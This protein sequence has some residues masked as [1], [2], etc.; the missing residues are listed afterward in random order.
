MCVCTYTE[1]GEIRFTVASTWNRIIPVLFINYYIIFYMNNCKTTVKIFYLF[2]FLYTEGMGGKE[3]SM[4][5]CLS[6]APYWEPGLQ[7]RHVP[8]LGIEPVTL[9]FSGHCSIH[10]ATPAR[11]EEI[12][13]AGPQNVFPWRLCFWKQTQKQF[14]TGQECTPTTLRT[15]KCFWFRKSFEARTCLY[16]FWYFNFFNTSEIFKISNSFLSSLPKG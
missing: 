11:A 13:L 5:V 12:F 8:S 14:S 7:P 4:C 9:W 10:R 6:C 16:G 1:W 2:I 15:E 3:T